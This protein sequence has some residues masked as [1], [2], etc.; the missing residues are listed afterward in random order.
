[1]TSEKRCAAA[2]AL[3]LALLGCGDESDP[4]GAATGTG[5]AASTATGSTTTGGGA[6]SSNGS[7]GAGA[8]GGGGGET[9][10]GGGGD[11]GR[12]G[13]GGSGGQMTTTGCVDSLPAG[14][15]ELPC[16]GGIVYDVEVPAACTSQPCGLIVD[17]HGFTMNGDS[18]DA[19]TGMRALGQQHGYV[20]V[21]P[22]APGTPPGWTQSTDA[23]LVFAFLQDVAIVLG[24]DPK[25]AH[26]MGFSQGGGMTFR[27]VCAHADFFASVSPIGA[28]TGCEFSGANTPSEEVDIL[29]V[30]GHDDVI[31][32]FDAVAV[33]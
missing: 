5:A 33:P 16:D 4:A 15:H 21:Q 32:D 7:S 6:S 8:A 27:M 17:M 31:V 24:T 30:H 22:T 12:S 1:M 23:P 14:H 19:N 26:A 13:V 28:I 25:R 18:E 29:Q 2:L 11:G 10:S 9:Q 20:V 3:F